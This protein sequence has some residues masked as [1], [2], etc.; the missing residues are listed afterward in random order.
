[1][2]E[3]KTYRI[4]WSAEPLVS[5]GF[6]AGEIIE[7]H[8]FWEIQLIQHRGKMFAISNQYTN[9]WKLEEI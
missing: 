8:K 2:L 1:M 6:S 7:I 4:V 9:L 3:K 5:K